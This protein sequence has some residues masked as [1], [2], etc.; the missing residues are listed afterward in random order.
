MNQLREYSRTERILQKDGTELDRQPQKNK[1]EPGQG[2]SY[3]S[4]MSVF[5]QSSL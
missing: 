5:N 2:A 4:P 1:N 3:W